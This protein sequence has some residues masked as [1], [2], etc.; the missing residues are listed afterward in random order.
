VYGYAMHA[1]VAHY[2]MEFL[3]HGQVE[4]RFR[5]PVYAG[6][7][8]TVNARSDGPGNGAA[9]LE[10]NVE[11]ASGEVC[12]IGTA[13]FPAPSSAS[14]QLP[15]VAPLGET[16]RP[17]TPEALR[18]T[19]VLGTFETR[20]DVAQA[21]AFLAVLGETLPH[22]ADIAHPAWLLRQANYLIDR[23]LALGP[24]IHVS[25]VVQ[26]RGVVHAGERI[27][28]RGQVIDLSTHKGNDYA[29]FDIVIMTT[30]P[31]MRIRHRAI[32]RMGAA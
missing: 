4:V 18:A 1:V 20:F 25:S 5:R 19:P 3:S 29:D 27:A 10:F 2:G 23:N 9:L 15:P 24:W 31:V 7:T 17:A 22:Y 28:V 13:Q 14:A 11:N 26:H 30:Q 8:I 12:A 6:E 21:P 16:R 32:Y